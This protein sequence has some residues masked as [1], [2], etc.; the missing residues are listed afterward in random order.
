MLIKIASASEQFETTSY[1]P[2]VQISNIVFTRLAR[3]DT[4]SD[5]A[6]IC[7]VNDHPMPGTQEIWRSDH[8][9]QYRVNHLAFKRT[10]P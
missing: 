6:I 5:L 1:R 7:Q 4:P 9:G 2:L 8:V 3:H 10:S